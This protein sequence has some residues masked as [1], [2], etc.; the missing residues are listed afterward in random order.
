MLLCF[1]LKAIKCI[2][3][4]KRQKFILYNMHAKAFGAFNTAAQKLPALDGLGEAVIILYFLGFSKVARLYPLRHDGHIESAAA[5]I[6]RCR[7]TG[8]SRADD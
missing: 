5:G 2:I 6:E 1:R 4:G 8:R 7:N 3:E